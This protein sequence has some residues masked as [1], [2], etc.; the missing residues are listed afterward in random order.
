MTSIGEKSRYI[1][2]GE[3]R[4][5]PDAIL[6]RI[7]QLN[8]GKA[9]GPDEIPPR[10]I[11]ELGREL[12]VP[13]SILFNKSLELGKIPVE[14]KNAN[15]VAIFKKGT[16]SNP[17]NYRPVSLTCVSCKI[18]ESVIRDT[19]V[20]HMND[21]NLSSSSSIPYRTLFQ[22]IAYRALRQFPRTP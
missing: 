2:T 4:V 1:Y 13:L 7:N 5:T 3:I 22:C 6:Q 17:G 14:W 9:Q 20:E 10:V 15:V 18:L 19:I 12:S 21:Y 8:R 11:Y 16:K